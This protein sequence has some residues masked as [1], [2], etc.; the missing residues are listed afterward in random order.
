M[1]FSPIIIALCAAG[2]AQA[3]DWSE[4]GHD[5][6]KN[7]A[8]PDAKNLPVEISGGEKIKGTDQIDLKSATGAKWVTKLGSQSYGTKTSG[9]GKILLGTNNESPRIPAYEGDHGCVYCLDEKTG[10]FIWQLTIPKLGAGK[11][12]DWEFLGVCSSPNIVGDRAYVITNRCEVLCID[13]NGLADGNQGMQ[14]EGKYI[15][16]GMTVSISEGTGH[17]DG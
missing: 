14:D 17:P 2:S 6:S 9:S 8:V 10:E 3:G 11:V 12:S 1:K 5:A 15:V 4:W 7:M 16:G 13:P